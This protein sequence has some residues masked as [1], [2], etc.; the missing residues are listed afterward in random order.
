MNSITH[1][2]YRSVV[3]PFYKQIAG[4]AYFLFFL[5]F[6]IQPNF[7]QALNTHYYILKSIA[8]NYTAFGIFMLL[9]LLYVLKC[10]FFYASRN[11]K[12]EYHFLQVLNGIS[13]SKRISSF[14]FTSL[15]LLMPVLLYTFGIILVCITELPWYHAM[16]PAALLLLLPAL[17]TLSLERLNSKGAIF[18]EVSLTQ[19]I[20]LPSRL[21]QFMLRHVFFEQFF[22]LAMLKL[23]SFVCLYFFVITD[24]SVFEGRMLWLFYTLCLA[25][26]CVI[27]YKLFY[28]L[29]NK[30]SFYRTLPLPASGILGN[31]FLCYLILLLPEFWALRALAVQ[32][33]QPYE[34]GCMLLTGPAVLTLLHVLLYTDDFKMDGYLSV[35]FLVWILFFFMSFSENKWLPP[36][37]AGAGVLIVFFT[38]FRSFE[39]KANIEKLE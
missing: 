2:L 23:V 39:K 7:K 34:Y 12:N 36:L 18:K 9:S 26:H 6:G 17:V 10:I 38:S 5:L 29:E 37:I 11:A 1:I 3:T 8:G 35:V 27:I 28:F 25:G 4:A 22:A 32:H 31:L 16:A 19:L 21:W 14:A 30:L 13:L 33:H 20:A 15:L 24:A